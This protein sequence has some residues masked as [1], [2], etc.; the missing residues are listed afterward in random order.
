MDGTTVIIII[1][2]LIGLLT[3]ISGL[4]ELIRL[5]YLYRKKEYY[6]LFRWLP[7]HFFSS[8]YVI[9]V[10]PT[11]K[12]NNPKLP[13]FKEAI[14]AGAIGQVPIMNVSPISFKGIMFSKAFKAI[15]AMGIGFFVIFIVIKTSI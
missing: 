6:P 10:D 7:I 3:F 11:L 12:W 4:I 15:V 8:N 1:F 14:I 9:N 13:S 2:F 5:P